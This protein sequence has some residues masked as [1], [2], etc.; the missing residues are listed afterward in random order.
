MQGTQRNQSYEIT[1]Y[2][3]PT[4]PNSP[5]VGGWSQPET[6]MFAPA[7]FEDSELTRPVES[8]FDSGS[9]SPATIYSCLVNNTLQRH[10]KDVKERHINPVNYSNQWKK[11]M[12]DL[13]V[14]GNDSVL[15]FLIKPVASN[16]NLSQVEQLIRRYSRNEPLSQP[17]QILGDLVNDISGVDAMAFMGEILC[18]KVKENAA[19]NLGEQVKTVY[20]TYR[21]LMEEIMRKDQSINAKLTKLDK[22][23][24]RLTMLLDLGVDE[25]TGNL[26]DQIQMYLEKVYNE[27]S[28]E[29]EYRELLVL[30]KKMMVVR[31]LVNLLRIS[32]SP[33]KEPLCGICL[34]ESVGFA[35]VPCGHTY[36]ENCVRRQSNTCF[37]CRQLTTQKMKIFFS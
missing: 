4:T 13:F 18:E 35:L 28:P 20:E 16:P 26:E 15:K 25:S 24:P 1:A 17:N 10:V 12:R 22:I 23:Q 27:N 7:N 3:A 9:Q 6:G 31:D 36:C 34:N 21:E 11:K 30:Y 37:V 2:T 8:Y 33:D 19:Q 14:K 29:Q 32:S 5:Q